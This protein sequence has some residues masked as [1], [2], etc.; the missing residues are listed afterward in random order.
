MTEKVVHC[1]KE[2]F[3]VYIGRGRGSVWGNP[4]KMEEY[5]GR[6]EVI[7]KYKQWL[8]FGEGRPLLKRLGELEGKTLGC[9]CA[10]YGGLSAGDGLICHGQILL[11]LLQH[12][13]EKLVPRN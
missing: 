5:G 3:D 8:I 9:W 13:R 10:D 6:E 7:E 12:R 1:K 4:F 11:K 2:P